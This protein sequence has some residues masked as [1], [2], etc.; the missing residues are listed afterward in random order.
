MFEHSYC[1][2][3]VR[4]TDRWRKAQK[5]F[6][7]AGLRV[8]R[9]PAVDGSTYFSEIPKEWSDHP[10]RSIKG[11]M[12]CTL[13]HKN[14]LEEARFEG[15][16]Q[17]AIFEDDIDIKSNFWDITILAFKQLPPEWAILYLGCVNIKDPTLYSENLYQSKLAWTTHSYIA[18]GKYYDRILN[19]LNFSKPIDKLWGPLF[20]EGL[21]F[22]TKPMVV[23]QTTD[24]SDILGKVYNVHTHKRNMKISECQD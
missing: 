19:L 12:G 23:L 2:N 22:C 1:I 8:E 17:V 13:S 11:A 6:I 5:E 15:F 14:L 3:L 20:E 21:I 18:N 16:E 24:F 7:R 10:R 9:F 4:R